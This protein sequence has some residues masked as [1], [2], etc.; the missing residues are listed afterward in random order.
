VPWAVRKA[1]ERQ[2]FLERRSSWVGSLEQYILNK[3]EVFQRA[4]V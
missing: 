2:Q 1:S 4:E 3:K